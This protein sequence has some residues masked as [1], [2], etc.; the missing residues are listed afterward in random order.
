MA[1]NFKRE[2]FDPNNFVKE[3]S[4]ELIDVVTQNPEVKTFHRTRND[5]H[6]STLADYMAYQ[7]KN[8]VRD[9]EG[10]IKF[11]VN[12]DIGHWE[13]QIEE[14]VAKIPEEFLFC[15]VK[16]ALQW[17]RSHIMGMTQPQ[18]YM[19]VKGSWTGGH[20]ENLR[21]R[22]VNLNHG[23]DSSEWNL[24]GSAYSAKLRQEVRDIYRTDIYKK[25]GLWF[26]DV[27]FCLAKKIPV[28]CFNQVKGD[29]VILGPG[30][31]HWVRGFG[32]AVQ[33]AWNFGTYDEWQFT[34]SIKRMDV[35]NNINYT[36][37]LYFNPSSRS[38]PTGH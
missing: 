16:D 26:A 2:L 7:K 29:L 31:E 11:A 3:H 5:R 23:P 19:K 12:I 10:N 25:E 13:P 37:R 20:E 15:S 17:V 24:V 18:M 9:E 21:Y 32:K 38:Y 6:K 27:D 22:A 34:E 36:V 1:T 14:L 33:T 4:N 28:T 8:Q 30:C 35:N